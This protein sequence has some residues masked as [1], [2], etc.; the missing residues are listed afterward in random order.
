MKRRSAAVLIVSMTWLPTACVVIEDGEVGVT[1]SF[2]AIR[3]EPLP[4]GVAFVAPIVRQVET[5]DRIRRTHLHFALRAANETDCHHLP[6]SSYC[7]FQLRR[8]DAPLGRAA[9]RRPGGLIDPRDSGSGTAAIGASYVFMKWNCKRGELDRAG[10][11]NRGAL[12]E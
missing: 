2:G 3:D 5:L 11:D 12:R 9:P 7:L 8:T 6:T 10:L 4:A 1:K